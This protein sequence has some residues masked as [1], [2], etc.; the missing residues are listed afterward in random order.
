VWLILKAETWTTRSLAKRIS[1]LD[2][3][4]RNKSVENCSVVKRVIGFLTSLG[5]N[6]FHCA[7]CKTQDCSG[8]F[9]GVIIKDVDSNV[10]VVCVQCHQSSHS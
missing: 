5:I 7:F 10:A 8:S 3:E 6:P 1:T 4:A 9:W 2:H